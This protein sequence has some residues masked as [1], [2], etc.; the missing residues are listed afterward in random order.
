ML[1]NPAE[2][3]ILVAKCLLHCTEVGF[4]PVNAGQSKRTGND[5][6]TEIEFINGEGFKT[7]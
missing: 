6:E 4:G 1:G 2:D 3:V 5:S 7:T